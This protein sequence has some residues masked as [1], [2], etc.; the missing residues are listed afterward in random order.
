MFGDVIPWGAGRDFEGAR[1]LGGWYE[2]NL[3]TVQ[4]LYSIAEDTNERVLVII[5]SGHVRVLRHLLRE[6]PMFCP[7]SPLPFLG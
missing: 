1:L 6:A 4:N 2:R 5:G 3:R 7:V